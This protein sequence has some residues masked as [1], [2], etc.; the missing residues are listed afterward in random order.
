[1]LV[2]ERT[3]RPKVRLGAV[4]AIAIAAGAATWVLVVRPSDQANVPAP[5]RG[6]APAA[7][8]QPQ[9]QAQ[10]P[11]I[12]SGTA[13]EA[14]AK[15][16]QAPVYWAGTRLHTRFELTGGAGRV[17]VRYLRPGV[18][19]GSP[20]ADFLTVGTYA[21]TDAFAHIRA[22]SRRQ[23]AVT[24]S[25]PGGGL[26]VY[27]RSRPTNVFLAYPAADTQ[28]EVYDPSPGEARALV[29]TGAI[30][31]IADPVT[32]AP[33]ALTVPAIQ[34]LAASPGMSTYWAGPRRG[35]VYEVTQTADGRTYIRYLTSTEQ[36]GSPQPVFLTVGT[37][38]DPK[39]FEHVRAVGR[40]P[41]A[42]TIPLPDGV[43]AVYVASHPTSV[44]L[45][46]PGASEQVE[47]YS[48]SAAEA[49]RLVEQGR[50]R[51]VR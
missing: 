33:R 1:M 36:V 31:A 25:V 48:P 42:V 13:L 30:R 7:A 5:T 18:A 29:Q 8:A 27:S 46:R 35:A 43:L 21:Q 37:Y 38:P 19:A 49:R 34:S 40:R 4:A 16:Q 10:P 2:A 44:Y 51:P 47:V 11:R 26:A 6:A 22:A 32:A 9:A 41:G 17:Y 3:R 14:F 28:I 12:V 23:G 45:A 39:A 24:I 20:R 15:S 50:V